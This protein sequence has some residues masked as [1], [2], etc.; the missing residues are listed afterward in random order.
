MEYNEDLCE[1]SINTI[2]LKNKLLKEI[3]ALKKEVLDILIEG[4]KREYENEEMMGLKALD[5]D[6]YSLRFNRGELDFMKISK[7]IELEV[8]DSFA[9]EYCFSLIEGFE[10]SFSYYEITWDY[11]KYF[12]G[13]FEQNSEK[14]KKLMK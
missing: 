1:I 5:N 6:V 8:F 4:F 10:D 13:V 12:D 3:D 7:L 2:L 11:K 14:V 9:A